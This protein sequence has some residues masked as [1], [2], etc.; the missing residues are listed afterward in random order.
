V[1]SQPK[2]SNNALSDIVP[3]GAV[4]KDLDIREYT[5]PDNNPMIPHTLVLF[6]TTS[7]LITPE[8]CAG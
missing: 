6:P 8:H 2:E 5:D 3:G 1:R 4:Q 7:C